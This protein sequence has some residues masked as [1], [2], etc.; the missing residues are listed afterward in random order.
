MGVTG[1]PYVNIY[2]GKAQNGTERI[3]LAVSNDGEKWER[4]GDTHVFDMKEYDPNTMI[5]GDP[6]IVC[7]GDIYVMFFFHYTAGKGAYNTFACSRD[8]INWKLWEGE[9]LVE[10]T[11]SWDNVHAHK[12]WFV[13][14]NDINYHYYCAV[15]NNNERFIA[16]ATSE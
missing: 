12:S 15:N 10:P 4:Y 7:I 3:F 5:T 2:N 6:Q 1:Y 11:E 16:V 13:R 14:Y 9:S 8:L